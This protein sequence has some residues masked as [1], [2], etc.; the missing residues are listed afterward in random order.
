MESSRA[1]CLSCKGHSSYKH[2]R[3]FTIY[4]FTIYDPDI[5]ERQ[6]LDLFAKGLAEAR[7]NKAWLENEYL[8]TKIAKMEYAMPEF[9]SDDESESGEVSELNI[10][11]TLPSTGSLMLNYAS[12]PQSFHAKTNTAKQN[13]LI[14]FRQIRSKFETP[15]KNLFW[16]IKINYVG[17]FSQLK[18]C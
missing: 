17:T 3:P 18:H 14:R 1:D 11:G 5:P 15:P 9:E 4:S 6:G 16:E 10:T 8:S 7:I 12:H 13:I 2:R